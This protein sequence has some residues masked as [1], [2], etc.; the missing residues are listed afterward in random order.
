MLKRIKFAV[1]F[2]TGKALARDIEFPDGTVAITGK[3]GTGKSLILEMVTYALWG[4]EATRG[5]ADDYKR[6]EVALDFQVKAEDY[7]IERTA[8]GAVLSTKDVETGAWKPFVSGT[9]AVNTKAVELFGYALPVFQVS[10]LIGQGQIEALGTMRPA[11][12]KKL[13]DNVIGLDAIDTV[14]EWT[15]VEA[16]AAKREADAVTETLREPEVPVLPEG[17]QPSDGLKLLIEQL[18][19][20]KTE[21]DEING[22]MAHP[23]PEPCRPTTTVEQ[24]AEVLKPL[25]DDFQ[26]KSA[27]LT[28]L[29]NQFAL[30]P[31][32][33][34]TLAEI[35]TLQAQLNIH[36]AWAEYDAK[37]AKLPARP[38]VI[39]TRDEIA[40]LRAAWATY[41]AFKGHMVT[42]PS[43]EHEFAPAASQEPA[44][45]HRTIDTQESLILAWERAPE[46]PAVSRLTVAPIWTQKNL[47]QYRIAAE[48]AKDRKALEKQIKAFKLPADPTADY[49]TRVKFEADLAGYDR[50]KLRYDQW[51]LAKSD[52]MVRLAEIGDVDGHLKTYQEQYTAATIYER[53]LRNYETALYAY[54]EA[55]E[56]VKLTQRRSDQY[57][58][59][60]VA[61]KTL[62]TRIKSFL[63]PSLS[64][65]AT[66]L[67]QQMTEGQHQELKAVNISEDFDITVDGQSL[68][69]LN[70][71]GKTVANLALR[72]GLGQILTNR[73]FSVLMADEVDAACDDERAAAIA[74][75]LRNL[76]KTIKQVVIVSHKPI[77]ADH[78]LAL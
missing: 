37:V 25:V 71:S 12:R 72:L 67:I 29:K 64:R 3:N 50:L 13:V 27:E 49:H 9:K 53:I 21:R 45:D 40:S 32:A 1:T 38:T 68:E 19:K 44:I 77:E 2:P 33:E 10:N 26:A 75:C 39:T 35:E 63:V 46:P 57:K 61:L 18:I 78:F 58:L 22:W 43:C 60:V 34:R 54:Q 14:A 24:T 41:E 5:S 31:E 28:T 55:V 7:R 36:N 73:V 65:V 23:V 17:Y 8:K 51:L 6:C 70:G 11:E 66:N 52:K 47:D 69:T 4:M 59:A 62:K 16:L 56:K 15:N 42:C 48:K 20:V 76:T 30:I 74:G